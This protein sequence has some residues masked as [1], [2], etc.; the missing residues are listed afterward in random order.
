MT[1]DE[2]EPKRTRNMGEL[3]LYEIVESPHTGVD[4]NL[5]PVNLPE[6]FSQTR[7]LERW[8][9]SASPKD[10]PDGNYLVVRVVKGLSVKSVTTRNI[11]PFDVNEDDTSEN[12]PPAKT[13]VHAEPPAPTG[14]KKDPVKAAEDLLGDDPRPPKTPV[15]SHQASLIPKGD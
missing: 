15:K 7:D 3:R 10:L 12:E 4:E 1:T 13:P 6:D 8:V 5:I 11:D 14:K 2:K 9:G